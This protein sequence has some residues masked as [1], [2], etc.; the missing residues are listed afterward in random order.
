MLDAHMNTANGYKL[1]HEGAEIHENIS[2]RSY[3]LDHHLLLFV[4]RAASTLNII[5][6]CLHTLQLR[7]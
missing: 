1:Q 4:L 5:L 6:R 7:Q 2:T 3:L